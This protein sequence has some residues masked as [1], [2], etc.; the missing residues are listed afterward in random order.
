M[1]KEADC[2]GKPLEAA[3][4]LP[5]GASWR[6][7]QLS[8]LASSAPAIHH[9][10]VRREGV[11]PAAGRCMADDA[12]LLLSI[13]PDVYLHVGGD[14]SSAALRARFDVVVDVSS[15]WTRLAFAGDKAVDLLR[16]G[17]AVDLHPRTFPAGTCC[18][19]GFARMRVVLWRPDTDARY[20]MLVARS[21]A[22]SLWTW[23]IDAAAQYGGQ[24]T[25]ERLQ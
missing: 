6:S 19:T 11:L 16:K 4:A 2:M 3:S 8:M 22:L 15:A 24:Q 13:G 1:R 25:K 20:E 21:Y 5:Q 9:L 18:A 10:E 23:L 7:E 12:G 14:Y 17:C